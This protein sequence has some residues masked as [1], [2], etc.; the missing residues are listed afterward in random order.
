MNNN[1]NRKSNTPNLEARLLT[2]TGNW[3][4][5]CGKR[6]LEETA[7]K[8]VKLYDIA[9]IYPYSPTAD[10]LAALK[11]VP[12]AKNIESFENKILLC[13]DCHKKQDF[14][15][16]RED[17]I[18][19]YNIKQ[20]LIQRTKAFDDASTIPI[21]NEI[22]DVLKK[23]INVDSGQLVPLSYEIVSVDKKITQG[24][25]L[26]LN[27]IRDKVVRYFLYVQEMLRNIDNSRSQKSKIIASEIRTCFLKMGDEVLSQEEM[28]YA[29]VKW[30]QSKTQSQS[31]IACEI[32]I[33]YFV[34]DCEVFDVITQ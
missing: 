32:I 31:E 17:Y 6:L 10:Q 20:Q 4:P 23:L 7:G 21:E 33:A 18:H 24:N 11:D 15:T 13:K 1:Q 12:V 29:L 34:Q 30:L 27:D 26:L 22:E 9:H 25:G 2:E 28:F 5:L 14:Y 8:S 3:C 19:L 16:Q